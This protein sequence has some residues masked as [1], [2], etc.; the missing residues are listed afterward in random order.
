MFDIYFKG[1]LLGGSLIMAIGMQNAFVLRQGL[2]NSHVF[3]TALTASLCDMILIIAGVLGFGLLVQK[4]PWLLTALKYGGALF[5]FIYGIK[6]FIR[7]LKPGTL[8]QDKAAGLLKKEGLK[9][10]I[11][12]LLAFSLLNPHVYLDTVVLVGGLS[13]AQGPIGKY[14]FGAGAA[15]ASFLWFFALAYA[16]RWMGPLFAKSIAWKILDI[17]IGI[18]MWWIAISLLLFS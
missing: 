6:S 11:L 16:G 15:S 13:A 8:D 7:A 17:L 3:P 5:L 18:I 12:L 10:T 14:W 9:E 2:K 1:L 4:A